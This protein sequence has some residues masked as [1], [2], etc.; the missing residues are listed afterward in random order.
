VFRVRAWVRVWIRLRLKLRL[1][2]SL[3]LRHRL[4]LRPRI[5][6][7][8]ALWWLCRGVGALCGALRVGAMAWLMVGSGG[9]E[10]RARV[11]VML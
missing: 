1:W 11:V 8:I 3:R 7:L 6:R 9:W 4:R 2:V 10:C 5:R